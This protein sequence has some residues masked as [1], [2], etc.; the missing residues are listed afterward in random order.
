MPGWLFTLSTLDRAEKRTHF[1]KPSPPLDSTYQRTPW[2]PSPERIDFSS[3]ASSSATLRRAVSAP[4]F[5]ATLDNIDGGAAIGRAEIRALSVCV[6][7][8]ANKIR[9]IG[10]DE[11]LA[12]RLVQLR[13]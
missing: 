11:D 6:P 3:P 10:A 9:V 1:P 4:G 2:S 7:S 12:A 5:R 8:I 13:K